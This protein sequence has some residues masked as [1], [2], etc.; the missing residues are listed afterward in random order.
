MPELS[1]PIEGPA[2]ILRG[3][4]YRAELTQKQLAKKLNIRQHHL[5]E[6]E[7]AKRSIGKAMAQKLAKV[8]EC[9]FRIFF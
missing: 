5:S 3:L 2:S 1:D 7:N 6:M 9:D 4:R 8:F